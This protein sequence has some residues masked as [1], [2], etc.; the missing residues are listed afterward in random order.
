[1]TVKGQILKSASAIALVT[2]ISRICGYLRDQRVALLLGTSPAAD[3][4]VLALRIPNLIRRMTGEGSLGASFIPVFTGYLRD[5]PRE[6]VWAFARKAFWDLAVLLGMLALLG[7]IFS[8]QVIDIYTVFAADRSHWELAVYLNRIIFPAVFFIGLAALA[9]AILHSFRIFALPAS[10]PIFLNLVFILFSFGIVYQPVMRMAPPA[11]RT[12]AVALAIGFLLGSFVQ[13]A[14]Q[15]PALVRQ[16]MRFRFALSASDPGIRKVSRLMGPAFFGMSVFQI[17][18]YVDTIFAASPLMPSG[19]V[20]S[21]YFGDR[22]MQLVLGT[23]AIAVS[24]ALL[25][26]MS[27]QVADG[28]MDEMKHT[29]GF[30]VRIV[31]FVAIPA[32]VGLILLRQP[33]VQVLFQHGAFVTEST[34]LTARVLFYY[35]LGLP[36]FAVIKLITP[37]YYSTHDTMTPARIG[38]YSLGL[39]VVLNL[40]FLFFFFRYFLNGSPAL[41]STIAAYFNFIALFLIFRKRHGALGSRGLVAALGKMAVCAVVMA[42]TCYLSLKMS[43]FAAAQHFL[44]QAGLLVALILGSTAIYFS[45][46]KLL[47]CEELSELLSLL[48]RAERNPLPAGGGEF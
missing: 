4:F 35:S 16:G 31:S 10:A 33:I 44:R 29:F 2:V 17:N 22:V 11:Y 47:R 48:R 43:G 42:I 7:V 28:K 36:A 46:A 21:L 6:E 41:A 32:A 40:I 25:P 37:M 20:T 19:S 3:S 39:N 14:V 15:I 8:R 24:T 27:H 9:S 30:S 34:A 26:T 13:L 23:V 12:P 5:K 38:A 1:M 18:Q 45:L